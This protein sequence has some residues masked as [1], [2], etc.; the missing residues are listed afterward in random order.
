[1]RQSII[2]LSSLFIV[3]QQT[4][5][6]IWIV[7]IGL[8]TFAKQTTT[9]KSTRIEYSNVLLFNINVLYN[10]LIKHTFYSDKKVSSDYHKIF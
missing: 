3:T 2:I 7:N 8:L 10:I 1:M 6:I 4:I 9:E 5:R